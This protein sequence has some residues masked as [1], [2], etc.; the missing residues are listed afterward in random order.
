[1][2]HFRVKH[3]K[4][5]TS[6]NNFILSD[7]CLSYK[8]KGIWLYAFSRPDNWKFYLK[9]IV[10][11]SSDGKEAVSTGLK[12]LAE[13]GYLVKIQTKVN[14]KFSTEYIFYETP[15][16]KESSTEPI[17]RSGKSGSENPPLLSTDTKP[18]TKPTTAAEP[19]AAVFDCLK[20]I[21]I[22][23][24][25]KEWLTSHHTE[26]DVKH[27]VAYCRHPKTVIKTSMA[28]TIKWAAKALPE[29]PVDESSLIEEHSRL[30]HETEAQVFP[31]NA[32]VSAG[33]ASVEICFSTGMNTPVV[34]AY[35]ERNFK[36]IFFDSLK[37][38]GVRKRKVA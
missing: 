3:D 4:D 27:A 32:Y 9:D 16:V 35:S 14:G 12:E 15:Q 29:L 23:L 20:E 21:R 37:R 28:Q 8:A 33:R 31:G 34:I 25:D 7:K 1:M 24:T 10:A 2:T 18:M 13:A 38:F 6:V 11:H 19:L 26:D 17:F 36:Q 5:Y 30:A 22:P